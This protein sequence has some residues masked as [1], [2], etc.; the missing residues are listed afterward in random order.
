MDRFFVFILCATPQSGEA[1]T[2]Y[3]IYFLGFTPVQIGYLGAATSFALL[4]SIVILTYQ[5]RKSN[6]NFSLARLFLIWTLIA[7]V[8][9]FITLILI[10]RINVRWGIPDFAFMMSDTVIIQVEM[11][12]M[13]EC[14]LHDARFGGG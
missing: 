10:F 5:S 2:Y 11:L 9:P 7:A 14:L 6:H 8:L 3:Q 4:V 12:N 13:A 1:V